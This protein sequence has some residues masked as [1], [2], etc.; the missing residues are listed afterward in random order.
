MSFADI[1][2]ES[3]GEGSFLLENAKEIVEELFRKGA[4]INAKNE[5]GQTAA[6][7]ARDVGNKEI[8]ALLSVK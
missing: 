1:Y 2:M 4:N 5:D 6:Q 3:L 8:A 7:I